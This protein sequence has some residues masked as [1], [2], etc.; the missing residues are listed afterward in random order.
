MARI[1]S[2]VAL[3]AS[4]AVLA[5]GLVATATRHWSAF[6]VGV[7]FI[8]LGSGAATVVL[9]GRLAVDRTRSTVELLKRRRS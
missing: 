8:L 3:A 1:A 7:V 5:W 2:E 4:A 6:F 9:L